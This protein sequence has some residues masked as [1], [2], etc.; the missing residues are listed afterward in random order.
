VQIRNNSHCRN[1]LV[2]GAKSECLPFCEP[3]KLPWAKEGMWR[4]WRRQGILFDDVISIP[5]KE[6]MLFL[7][8]F[9]KNKHERK[10]Q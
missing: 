4:Q 7:I 9:V 3:K 10:K 6:G 8:L 5:F 2:K 1:S